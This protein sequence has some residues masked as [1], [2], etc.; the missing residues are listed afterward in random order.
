MQSYLSEKV[1]LF[2]TEVLDEIFQFRNTT[3]K[4]I[5]YH[6]RSSRNFGAKERDLATNII[7]EIL[8]F[9]TYFESKINEEKNQINKLNYHR[10][11]VLLGSLSILR[12]KDKLNFLNDQEKK[13]LFHIRLESIDEI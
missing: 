3:S 9:K 11:L 1:I 6:L 5:S 13:F 8:R 7:F 4:I 12:D 10:L 2:C